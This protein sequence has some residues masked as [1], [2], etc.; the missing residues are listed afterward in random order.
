MHNSEKPIIKH[1]ND[2]LDWT[3]IEK[4]LAYKSQENYSRFLQKFLE[5]S[6]INK[7]ENLKP[8]QMTPDHIFK[9]KTFLSRQ[10]LKKDKKPL[11]RNTQNYY[12]I[13]LRSLLTYFA[14][15]DIISLP[16]EKIKLTKQS[17]ER[18]VNF[19]TLE[20]VE[21]L[22]AIPNLNDIN[23]LRDR[24]ILETLFSTGLRVAEL[25][26][27][28]RD[29]ITIKPTTKDLEIGIVGKGGHPRT[30]FL[31]QR[32]IDWLQQYLVKRADKE[33]ALFVTYRGPKV[34]GRITTRTIERIIKKYV[35]LAGLPITTTPHTLRH[36][37]ATDLL[38]KGVDL[39]VVQE[40]LGHR[41]IVTTQI[42]THVTRPHLKEIHRKYHG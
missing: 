7:L 32:T 27:L 21:K 34:Q 23:G 39:R 36:S 18:T 22:L 37:F 3:D 17:Q 38:M 25:V 35:V 20:Q 5:W 8:H 12:L 30:V 28:N 11:K 13:A 42:Y 15:K 10:Y 31:S 1:I 40:F 19:L 33:R 26:A 4:G 24:T 41:N 6:K 9:Y 2:F 29:Q 14:D 16:P